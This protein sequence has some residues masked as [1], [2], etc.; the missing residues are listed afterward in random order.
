[1]SRKIN[2]VFMGSFTYPDG[3]A[4]TKRIQHAIDA[5]RRVPDVFVR[6]VLLRQL[7]C[8]NG[9]SGLHEGISYHTIMGGMTRYKLMILFPVLYIKSFL[10]FKQCRR[11]DCRN[12]IYHYGPVIF[13]NI[14]PLWLAKYL[15]YKIVFDIV[16]DYDV[17]GILSRSFFHRIRIGGITKLQYQMRNIASGFIVISSHLEGKYKIF[18]RGK[19]PVH[20][21][22]IS[23]DMNKFLSKSDYKMNNIVSL[24]YA[25]SFGKKDGLLELIDA[26]D[27]LAA[28][29]DNVR[30]ILTGRG[31]NEAMQAFFSRVDVSP[32]KD[33]IEYK[34]YL[35]DNTYYDMLNVSDI[36]CMTRVDL[37]YANAGFPFKLG[38]Y[39]ASGKPVIAS[40][41]SDVDRFLINKESAMLVKPGDSE[42]IMR[43]AEFL[44]DN[45]KAASLIGRQGREVAFSHFDHRV[46]GEALLSFLRRL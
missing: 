40:R 33:R 37:A 19:L 17:A 11:K 18:T 10:F 26:F 24:F 8:E 31:D 21:R 35:D 7:S 5:L 30:L 20:Y 4:G 14:V 13:E 34:G 12:I 39:L 44:I 41:V 15:G 22:P 16:E 38:E 1:M 3:M 29:R 45:P 32:F 6:V 23:I 27:S 43:A 9:Y 36:H 42:E 46:Q 2:I 28:K 25:G